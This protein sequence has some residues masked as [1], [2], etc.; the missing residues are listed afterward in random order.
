MHTGRLTCAAQRAGIGEA[1]MA[2]GH[3]GSASPSPAPGPSNVPHSPPPDFMFNSPAD[4]P[5]PEGE[6]DPEPGSNREDDPPP[7]TEKDLAQVLELLAQKIGG[8]PTPKN[9][10]SIKPLVPNTF[11]GSD[12]H[13][14]EAFIFQC[15]MYLAVQSGDF[16]D[17][18]SCIVC[19]DPMESS[20]L[21]N[22]NAVW[23]TSSAFIVER[24]ATWSRIV[25][26]H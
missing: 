4:P 5:N 13:E 17:D 10:S 21:R 6:P 19:L 15:Q 24:L 20:F 3:P 16:P 25:P 26:E 11:N 18:K 9:K 7:A 23:T 8:M 2:I 1:F 14:L 12:P 22:A